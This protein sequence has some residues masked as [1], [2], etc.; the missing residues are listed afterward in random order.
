MPKPGGLRDRWANVTPEVRDGALAAAVT[1]AAFVPQLAM[2]GAQF[3][4]LPR[5]DGG[6]A[7]ALLVLGQTLPLA[8]RS[9]W[10]ALTLA[11]IALCFGTHEVLAH[12]PTFGSL[13]LYFALYS[14]GAREERFRRAL[15]A[16]VSVGYVAFAVLVALRGSPTD[17]LTYV[18]YYVVLALFWALGALVRQ[19]RRQ[20]AERRRLTARAAAADERAR[21]ARELHDVV[22]HHV[23]AMVVQADAAQ[24]LPP[25][26]APEVFAAITGSGR[27]AL[28]ELRFLLGVLEATGARTPG[29]SALPGLVEQPGRV[30]DL[31]EAGE[32]PEL[33]AETE[34]TAYRIVQ[35]A[36]TNAA[37][38]AAGR[39]ATVRVGY[40]ADLLEIEVTTRGPATEPGELGSGGRG[41]AGLRERV[42]ALGGRFAAGPSA[43]GFRVSAQFPVAGPPVRSG[44]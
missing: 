5:H 37:K 24:Y 12:S 30:V 3:G 34:L 20:E 7:A 6:L 27:E 10:P 40:G 43:D 2:V 15:P 31:V 11:I 18:V 19:R 35:E 28:T 38:H 42:D 26:T 36:L 39:P 41:L 25:G 32:R 9:R 29:L 14:A 13:A 16:A 22:T 33:P 4:D 21:L 44:R 17:L 23:T 1:A 8:V